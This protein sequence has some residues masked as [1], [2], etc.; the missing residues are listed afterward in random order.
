[1]SFR[2]T[3]CALRQRAMTALGRLVLW[4]LR[5]S[6]TPEELVRGIGGWVD[7]VREV[8]RAPNGAAALAMIFRYIFVVNERFGAD[9]LVGLL[10]QAVGEEGKE[11]MASVAEQLREEGERRGLVRGRVEG[12]VEGLLEGQRKLLLKQLRAR[13][14]ELTE[15]ALAR[16]NGADIAQLDIWAERVLSAPTLAEALGGP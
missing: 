3:L 14:G 2:L 5:S 13:F 1:M 12:R 4:C 9:E 15:A 11:E 8:R 7:L 10:G 16:V 6:R